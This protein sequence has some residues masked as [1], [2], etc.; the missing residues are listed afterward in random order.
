M[1]TPPTGIVLET[2]GFLPAT[3]EQYIGATKTAVPMRKPPIATLDASEGV[4][5]AVTKNPTSTSFKMYC[6]SDGKVEPC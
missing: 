6:C 4:K 3:A 5:N 2:K 1:P